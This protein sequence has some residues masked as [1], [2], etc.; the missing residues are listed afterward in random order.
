MS[1]EFD[2]AEILTLRKVSRY[3]LEVKNLHVR[4]KDYAIGVVISNLMS[5]SLP[6]F[7][8]QCTQMFLDR[9]ARLCYRA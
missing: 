1:L 9:Q 2:N 3:I 7:I 8:W 4:N 5:Q 6:M